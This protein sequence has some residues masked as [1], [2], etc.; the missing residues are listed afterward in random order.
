MRLSS[1]IGLILALSTM[2]LLSTADIEPPVKVT[3]RWR[4]STGISSPESV[5]F[6]AST[7]SLF[8]SNIVGEGTAHDGKASIVRLSPNG[9]KVEQKWLSEGLDA[10]K[11]MRAKN[12]VLWVSDINRIHSIEIKTA[13]I[14]KTI[15]IGNAK[16]LNDI[17][18]DDKG[19]IYISD[20]MG[21]VIYKYDGEKVSSWLDRSIP[22]P[23][24]L[25]IDG[26]EMIVAS[27]GE[28]IKK[29]WSVS[30]PGKL[31]AVDLETK[32]TRE[33]TRMP[34]G[35]LDGLEMYRAGYLVSDW[36]AGK[37]FYVSQKGKFQEILQGI[38][39]AADIGYHS[40]TSTLYVPSMKESKILAYGV[41]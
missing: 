12:G 25:L 9:K 32:K 26:R 4:S 23:N 40:K 39:G 17:E 3:E 15:K 7:N 41:Q 38:P 37:V 13:K 1:S 2:P 11:G 30:E 8:V 28:N 33:I 14:L 6:D 19:N 20:T 18:I 24:G 10:P 5:Y 16:F 29:D 35:N 36:V 34:V 27:W 21:N 22:A 31:F